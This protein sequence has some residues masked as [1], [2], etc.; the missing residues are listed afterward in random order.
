MTNDYFINK[1]DKN[2]LQYSLIDPEFLSLLA[3]VATMGAEKYS[4]NGWKTTPDAK[5]RYIDSMYRH[6][7]NYLR[8]VKVDEESGLPTL[9]HCAVNLMFVMWFDRG[10]EDASLYLRV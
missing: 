2:K 5:K 7:N 6:W 3:E 10:E 8:G 4:A 9:A 1:S